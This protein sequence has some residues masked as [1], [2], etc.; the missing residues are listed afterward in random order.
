[1]MMLLRR[2][3]LLS[4]LSITGCASPDPNLYTLAVIAGPVRPGGPPLVVLHEIN[5]AKYLEGIHIV[6]SS[7]DY[8]LDVRSN[9]WWGEPPASMLGHVLVEELTQ[10]LPG[11]DV[12]SEMGAIPVNAGTVVEVNVQRMDADAD[13]VVVL[14]AQIAVTD[15]RP[16]SVTRRRSVRFSVPA[17]AD[18]RAVVAAISVAVGQLADAIAGI[19]SGG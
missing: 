6:R 13:N 12:F 3:V 11:T 9:D 8:R 15:P 2:A 18:T 16:R 17:A 14:T 19:L 5:V 7:A 10:R 1:M 4:L